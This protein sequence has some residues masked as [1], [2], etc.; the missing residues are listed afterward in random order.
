[1]GDK[2]IAVIARYTPYRLD[3]IKEVRI[4]KGHAGA[5]FLNHPGR[6]RDDD[7]AWEFHSLSI[8]V[9]PEDWE[10]FVTD[11][12]VAL[13]YTH[14]ENEVLLEDFFIWPSGTSMREVFSWFSLQHPG[15]LKSLVRLGE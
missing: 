8:L 7:D 11:L 15:G 13:A 1:M 14:R 4:L 3:E 6:G 9:E 10:D 12:W 5:Y 2:S